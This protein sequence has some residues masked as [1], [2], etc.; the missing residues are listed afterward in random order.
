MWVLLVDVGQ[1]FELKGSLKGQ[2]VKDKILE[3]PYSFFHTAMS[4]LV[5]LQSVPNFFGMF[6]IVV[7]IVS[8]NFD[9]GP[10]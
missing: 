3:F 5:L 10:G 9:L 4:Q 2:D 6:L 7:S 8:Q 1:Y